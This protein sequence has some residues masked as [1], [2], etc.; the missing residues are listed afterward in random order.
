M[1]SRTF[2]LPT[3][4]VV[5]ITVVMFALLPADEASA[6]Q[7]LGTWDGTTALNSGT[8]ACGS[9]S[10]TGTATGVHVGTPVVGAPVTASFTY[11]D[12]FLTATAQGSINLAGHPCN[13]SSVRTG[14]TTLMSIGGTTCDTPGT[15]ICD[16]PMG[17][18]KGIYP[19]S[20]TSF[21]GDLLAPR[22]LRSGRLPMCTICA[23]NSPSAA[24]T[25]E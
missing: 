24:L 1:A 2:S 23:L 21:S 25:H 11:C 20:R 6:G 22:D 19:S 8:L 10:F 3:M 5:L 4:A 9:G 13:F 12:D 16:Y 17:G 7:F 15:A 18:C 14:A